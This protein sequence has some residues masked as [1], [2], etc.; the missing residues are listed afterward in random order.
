MFNY[1]RRWATREMGQSH[2]DK[3]WSEKA[4]HLENYLESLQWAVWERWMLSKLRDPFSAAWLSPHFSQTRV[5]SAERL[6][7]PVVLSP[8]TSLSWHWPCCLTITCLSS[9]VLLRYELVS[10]HGAKSVPHYLFGPMS[11]ILWLTKYA[12]W[13]WKDE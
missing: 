8:C 10:S 9:H 6:R 13:R 5:S 3:I 4:R 7:S 12:I 11:S 2:Y 1:I